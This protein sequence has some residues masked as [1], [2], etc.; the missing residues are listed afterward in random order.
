M[1]VA[2]EAGARRYA[3][4]NFRQHGVAAGGRHAGRFGKQR[5]FELAGIPLVMAPGNEL[6]AGSDLRFGGG[7][8]V[9]E[10]AG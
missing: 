10:E 1:P 4:A 2:D 9:S 5:V 7:E 8:R 6:E 3:G